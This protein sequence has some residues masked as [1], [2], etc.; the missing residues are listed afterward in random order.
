MKKEFPFNYTYYNG[1]FFEFPATVYFPCNSSQ[2]QPQGLQVI[3]STDSEENVLG[4]R[5]FLVR[6]GVNLFG[7]TEFRTLQDFW[8]YM[9]A[10]CQPCPPRFC[11]FT[12]NDCYAE[13]NGCNVLYKQNY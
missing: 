10:Y 9:N 12:I 6:Y 8:Q 4:N 5:I 1:E 3:A 7:S 13:I 2:V 11:Y